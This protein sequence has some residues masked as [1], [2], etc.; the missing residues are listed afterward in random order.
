MSMTPT[1]AAS[2]LGCLVV[3]GMAIGSW[4]FLKYR[5]LTKKFEKVSD[6][7]KALQKQT[8]KWGIDQWKSNN[9]C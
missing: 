8:C 5:G 6:E 7:L 3:F 4:G 9:F 2:V 1:V